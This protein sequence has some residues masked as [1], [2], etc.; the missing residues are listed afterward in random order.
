MQSNV[1]QGPQVQF[2]VK[3]Q[4]RKHSLQI[5]S[6]HCMCGALLAGCELVKNRQ[7]QTII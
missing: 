4:N 5:H 6:A 7:L 3:V 2:K 1:G